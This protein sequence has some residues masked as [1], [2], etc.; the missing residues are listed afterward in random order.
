[1]PQL[2]DT[3]EIETGDRPDAAVIWL[4]G[5]GADGS[6]FE[7]IVPA[8]GL[9]SRFSVRFI[10]PNAPVRPITINMGMRMPAWF[11]I[12]ELGGKRED[13]SGIRE[14]QQLVEEL[15]A[16]E[17]ARGIEA[18]RIVLAGF[19]QGGV[20]ALQAGLRHPERLA[21]IMALSTWLSL[22]GTLAAER[23]QKNVDVP[24]FMAHGSHVDMVALARGKNSMTALN[25]LGYAV[26]WHDYPMGHEVCPEEIFAIGDW[27][28]RIL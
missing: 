6:D 14:S 2:Q 13:E 1:M 7:P 25:A 9:P 18:R 4:H 12:V 11:D 27:L 24:I 3:I 28:G 15:I 26:E 19:S 10:F 22:T 17:K 23:A 16:Y 5:L 21:G 20:I 8:L